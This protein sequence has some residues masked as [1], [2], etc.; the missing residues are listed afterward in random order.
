MKNSKLFSD[1]ILMDLLTLTLVVITGTLLVCLLY[2]RQ[3]I[4]YIPDDSSIISEDDCGCEEF[5]PTRPIDKVDP[6]YDPY[7][8]TEVQKQ[9]RETKTIRFPREGIL[10]GETQ[11]PDI[12]Y[13]V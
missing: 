11:I 4:V 8:A 9:L 12:V 5:Q 10:T 7:I 3:Y 13:K 6:I 2:N 1:D